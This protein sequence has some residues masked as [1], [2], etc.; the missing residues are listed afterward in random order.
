MYILLHKSIG[1]VAYNVISNWCCYKC[2]IKQS[3]MFY[4][5]DFIKTRC[6][7]IFK[8]SLF[9]LA[10]SFLSIMIDS[11]IVIKSIHFP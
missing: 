5:D 9:Y 4:N 10:I 2:Y 11:P 1:S 8:D 7:M 6:V 3:F